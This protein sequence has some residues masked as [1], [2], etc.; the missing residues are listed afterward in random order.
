MK[1][2][3]IQFNGKKYICRIVES[4]DGEE[5][6]I[7]S[8]ELLDVLQPGS[9]GDANEGFACKEAEALYDEVFYFT[10]PEN[11]LLPDEELIEVLKESNP[12]WFE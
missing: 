9:F 7:G 12:D 5:L 10:E 6:L 1:T 8:T 11:L 2:K 4:I 3:E